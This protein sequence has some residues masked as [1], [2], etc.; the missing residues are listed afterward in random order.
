MTSFMYMYIAMKLILRSIGV[1]WGGGQ[2]GQIPPQY[3]F[4]LGI[5]YVVTE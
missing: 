5:V 4:N 3:F 2:G 1:T